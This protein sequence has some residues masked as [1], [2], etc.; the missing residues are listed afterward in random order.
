[1][2]ACLPEQLCWSGGRFGPALELVLLGR[3]LREQ[4]PH[5]GELLGRSEVRRRGDRD[6]LRR[7]VVARADER[8]RL[9]RLRRRTQERDEVRV[10][11]L[12]DDRAV[13]HGNRVDHVPRLDD[14]AAPDGDNDRI[15]GGRLLLRSHAA[16]ELRSSDARDARSGGVGA[17][18]RPAR[19]GV[20]GTPGRAGPH[21]DAEDLRPAAA[22]AR[23]PA[24]R[25]CAPA[26][27][28]VAL[29]DRRRRAPAAD[30]PDERRAGCATSA[31][32]DKGPKT[33]AFRL[34]FED[35]GELVL[36]EAG[37]KK[38]AGVWLD[39]PEQTEAELAH[40]GPEALGLGRRA[41]APR[42]S[43]ATTA[44]ST[45]SCATSARS[46]GSAGRT[47]TRSSTARSCRRSRSPRSST[48]RRSNGLRRR[49]TRTSSRLELREQ[50]KGDK[51]VY[52]VHRR[53]GEPCPR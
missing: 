4:A 7:Q 53:L 49:S 3:R 51:D 32:G 30:P 42:S 15:H 41:A 47:R 5:G 33:P 9:E 20:A 8:Q 36:T 37:P 44:G 21:R 34:R 19:V 12:L 39:T 11:G 23:R 43:K 38:R 22:R 14:L 29:P 24:V 16:S 25:G 48:T 13:A 1:M 2:P 35:G 50:G 6:L 40:L 18:A 46:P 27:E 31:A 26:R 52:L 10:A 28:V 17:G 45:R